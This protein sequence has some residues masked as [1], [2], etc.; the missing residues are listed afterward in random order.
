M[1]EIGGRKPA[2]RAA[3]PSLDQYHSPELD[4]L[5]L[6]T[7]VVD[8]AEEQWR[9]DRRIGEEL[10]SLLR[11]NP[12]LKA[13]FERTDAHAT[14]AERILQVGESLL[15]AGASL[16]PPLHL[17][18]LHSRACHW[19]AK[20]M[21]KLRDALRICKPMD[22]GWISKAKPSGRAGHPRLRLQMPSRNGSCGRE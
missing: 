12:L 6:Y 17:K 14:C 20:A 1:V 22:K 5:I 2:L 11:I 15:V 13:L 3:E 9:R 4:T 16:Q 10:V 18:A 19:T 8:Q 7:T 21:D